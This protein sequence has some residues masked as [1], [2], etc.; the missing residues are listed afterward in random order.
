MG[1]TNIFDFGCILGHP[2]NMCWLTVWGRVRL[3]E[4]LLII[5]FCCQMQVLFN[6]VKTMHNGAITGLINKQEDIKL[7]ISPTL[8]RL[9]LGG[10][11]GRKGN[12]AIRHDKDL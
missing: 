8:S 7:F 1:K 5:I 2:T 12:T 9:V 6:F 10:L 4:T 3:A 11:H